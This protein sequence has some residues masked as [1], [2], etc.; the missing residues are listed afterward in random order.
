MHALEGALRSVDTTSSF[1]LTKAINRGYDAY[2]VGA[3]SGPFAG[4]CDG[5]SATPAEWLASL[6]HAR[7]EMLA[8]SLLEAL[9]GDLGRTA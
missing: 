1:D 6:H 4:A 3:V 9:T 7:I 5:H 8:R 2:F